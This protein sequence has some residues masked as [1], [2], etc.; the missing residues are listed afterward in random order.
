MQQKQGTGT[1]QEDG[2]R[3]G[4]AAVPTRKSPASDRSERPQQAWRAAE[5]GL[6]EEEDKASLGDHV[7]DAS[8]AGAAAAD[9]GPASEASADPAQPPPQDYG[10]SREK[11]E[12]GRAPAAGSSVHGMAEDSD[13][14]DDGTGGEMWNRALG[15]NTNAGMLRFLGAIALFI[16]V[17]ASLFWFIAG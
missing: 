17:A 7:A 2:R 13:L 1:P 9:I 5:L 16:L 6:P 12:A 11:F 4:E 15:E 10:R 14:S 8:D 3:P